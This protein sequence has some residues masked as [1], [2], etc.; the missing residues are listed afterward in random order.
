MRY[1][2]TCSLA[3]FFIVSVYC[4]DDYYIDKNDKKNNE[5]LISN[6]NFNTGINNYTLQIGSGFSRF[7]NNSNFFSTYIAPS[8]DY[9]VNPKLKLNIGGIITNYN[10]NCNFNTES[11]ENNQSTYGF[12]N[13]LMYAKG[14]YLISPNIKIKSMV[15]LDM[16]KTNQ[17]LYNQNA[18]NLYGKEFRF[19]I[20]YKLSEKVHFNAEIGVSNR[21]NVFN[22]LAYPNSFY[23]SNNI[24]SPLNKW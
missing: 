18:D 10:L 22:N 23:H 19:G 7:S 8:F 15:I 12:S 6:Q 16:D 14:E 21:N 1:I 20:D 2:L 9:S 3:I 17:N 13:Y 24:F 5:S 11:N 4:Q